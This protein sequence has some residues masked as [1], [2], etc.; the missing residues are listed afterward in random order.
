MI[1]VLCQ[2][3]NSDMKDSRSRN[4]VTQ[5]NCHSYLHT[6]VHM[7]I[8]STP[9][10]E[11]TTAVR[12]RNVKHGATETSCAEATVLQPQYLCS[13]AVN[14]SP[15]PKRMPRYQHF[16]RLHCHSYNVM[17]RLQHCVYG[18]C[19]VPCVSAHTNYSSAVNGSTRYARSQACVASYHIQRGSFI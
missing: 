3:A 12:A 4:I 17:H 2:C 15:P 10:K 1:A 8:R 7:A 18:L 6:R 11:G 5:E 16:F 13:S 19:A 9:Q 14:I